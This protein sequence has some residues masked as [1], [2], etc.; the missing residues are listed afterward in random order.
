M[1]KLTVRLEDPGMMPKT[2]E[3]D[4]LG[5]LSAILKPYNRTY[6]LAIVSLGKTK[7]AYAT[8]LLGNKNWV[9]HRNS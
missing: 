9:I 6:T 1:E 3:L 5:S 8:R 2:I 7:V 4:C